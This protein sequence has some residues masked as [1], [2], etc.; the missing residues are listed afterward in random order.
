MAR[1]LVAD[2]KSTNR[3]FLTTLLGYGGHQLLEAANGAEALEQVRAEHPDLVIADVLMP[4]MDGYE[5]VRQ[6]RA[7]PE[8]NTT[9]VIFYTASYHEREARALARSCGVHQL[10]IKPAEPE[11]ILA[12]VAEALN[13]THNQA[14]ATGRQEFDRGHLRLL[15]DKLSENVNALEASNQRLADL[16]EVSRLLASEYEADQLL[17]KFCPAARELIGARFA[18][19]GVL[20]EDQ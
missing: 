19:V 5:F 8:I 16:L 18:F 2:D 6:L 15:T 4:V 1:V 3:E 11:Q 12:T 20:S 10:L 9:R 13:A 7:D 17:A 14:G